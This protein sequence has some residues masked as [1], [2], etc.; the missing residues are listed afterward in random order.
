MT[1]HGQAPGFVLRRDLPTVEKK[2]DTW[3]YPLLW[4]ENGKR[5]HG[6][7][8]LIYDGKGMFFDVR[9]RIQATDGKIINETN[10]LGVSGADEAIRSIRSSA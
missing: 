1:M 10:S 8:P 4:D 5:R 6:A 3:K 9:L 7:Q 2:P